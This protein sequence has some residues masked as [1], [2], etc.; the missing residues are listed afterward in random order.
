MDPIISVSSISARKYLTKWVKDVKKLADFAVEE[1]QAAHAAYTKG[2]S[3]RWTYVQRTVKETSDLFKP[4]EQAIREELIPALLGRPVSD[5]ERRL[6]ALPYR[7]GGLGIRN[8]VETADQEFTASVEVTTQLTGLLLNQD[9]NV[10]SINKEMVKT[11]KEN[12]TLKR[13][14]YQSEEHKDIVSKLPENQA[15]YLQ[16]ARE[17]GVSS[18]LSALPIKNLGYVLNKQ[19]WRDAICL[20]YGWSIP[21]MPRF[22]ACGKRNSIEHALDCKLGGYVHMRHNA[23]R[24]TEARIM[25]EVASDVK[26]EPALQPI[27][28]NTHLQH[29]TNVADGARLDVSAR[30][31]F[32]GNECTFFDVRI[33]NPNA[34]SNKS[35]KLSDLYNIHEKEKMKSYTVMTE[36]YKLRNHL[37][38]L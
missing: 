21:E 31:I 12:V 22:C 14:Q 37:L 20:R 25:R 17:K 13:N 3:Y 5:L 30:G 35:K 23:I 32:S 2:L 18:W 19:E 7:F 8:P 28:N 26:I 29:G 27:K 1:P 11:I 15:R 24:D 34:P 33:T 36:Y 16:S 9:Q 10:S 38:F 6:I 4:L